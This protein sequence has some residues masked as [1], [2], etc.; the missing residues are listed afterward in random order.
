MQRRDLHF[1]SL[2]E[3]Q[4][5]LKNLASG[6]YTKTAKW[7]LSQVAEHLADWMT[8]PIDGFPKPPWF[9][10]ILIGVMRATQGKSLYKKF[11]RDQRMA[12]GAPTIPTTVYPASDSSAKSVERLLK[13]I[14]RLSAHR[15]PIHPSPL[16]GQ[17]SYDE[18]VALQLAHCAHHLSFLVP[19]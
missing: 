19:S 10:G 9:V 3:V 13:A 5:D 8:F 11:V 7:D 1:A 6:T 15:G 2:S 4:E 17:L 18:L 12:T 16:F 14:D